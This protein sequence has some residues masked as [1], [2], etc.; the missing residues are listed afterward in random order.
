MGWGLIL[1]IIIVSFILCDVRTAIVV[2]TV[3]SQEQTIQKFESAHKNSNCVIFFG[4]TKLNSSYF[5]RSILDDISV[6]AKR[7]FL[8]SQL[9]HNID[10]IL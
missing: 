2:E 8:Q 5:L 6:G 7:L 10:W 9:L 4:E 1:Y 3:L